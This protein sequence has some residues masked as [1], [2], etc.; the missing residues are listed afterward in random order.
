MIRG[1]CFINIT[2]LIAIIDTRAMY[3]FIYEDCDES[4]NIELTSMNGSMVV[5]T[6]ALGLVRTSW[7]CLNYLLFV[8]LVGILGWT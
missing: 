8:F 7:V 2:P 1:T 4:L 5:D 6:H 3:F